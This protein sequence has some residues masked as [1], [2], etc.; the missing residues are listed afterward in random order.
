MKRRDVAATLVTRSITS[1]AYQ[2]T[3]RREAL[4]LVGVGAVAAP[5]SSL[6]QQPTENT[7]RIGFLAGGGARRV[8]QLPSVSGGSSS[9]PPPPPSGAPRAN[10]LAFLNAKKGNHI[11][12][13]Q[14]S[15]TDRNPT[16]FDMDTTAIGQPIGLMCNNLWLFEGTSSFDTS[17]IPR[18]IAHYQAGGLVECE[19]F[20]PNPAAPANSR[21]TAD[22][23]QCI[24]PGTTLNNALVGF[25]NQAAGAFQQ[26][27]AQ[28]IPVI[29]RMMHE[30]GLGAFWWD[31]A[32]S[33]P[34]AFK[35]MW[36]YIHD[37]LMITKGCDNL[38]W[39]LGCD[40][41]SSSSLLTSAY[42]GDNYVDIVGYDVYPNTNPSIDSDVRPNFNLLR[43]IAPSKPTAFT[44]FGFGGPSVPASGDASIFTTA[45]KDG[46][47]GPMAY[48]MM[49][50]G[51]NWSLDTNLSSLNDPVWLHR[52]NMNRGF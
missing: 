51:W 46:K 52:N 15:R 43:S 2:M 20:I 9:P 41:N 38:V 34:A 4:I 7:P 19:M 47:F 37:Y 50:S 26:Y 30:F 17:F 35:A 31:A 11:I 39:A 40:L 12:A 5:F 21:G 29:T 13:G 3:T 8:V 49:W 23:T 48:V 27:R 22:L 36:I 28:G 45:A 16:E 6:A 44:E 25:L 33:G 24:T 18:Q 42:P 10:L 32:R 1:H 14:M